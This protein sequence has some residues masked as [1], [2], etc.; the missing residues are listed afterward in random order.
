LLLSSLL[1]KE[2]TDKFWDT[3]GIGYGL[4]AID[5][6]KHLERKGL[7]VKALESALLLF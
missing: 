2:N 5:L 4:R 6:G 3:G 7:V 1:L